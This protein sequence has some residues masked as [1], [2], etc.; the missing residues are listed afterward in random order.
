MKQVRGVDN[1][2]VKVEQSGNNSWV[3]TPLEG[4]EL[5]AEQ[6]FRVIEMIVENSTLEA[7]YLD[8]ELRIKE[9]E[10]EAVTKRKDVLSR[11]F[12]SKDYGKLKANGGE[13][14]AI[15]HIIE[16]EKEAGILK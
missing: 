7:I 9:P 14:D 5:T 6:A 15:N 4:C 1:S 16:L 10:S 12:F 13:T 3:T 11:R 2:F 8:G